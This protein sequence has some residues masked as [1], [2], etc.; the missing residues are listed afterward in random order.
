MSKPVRCPECGKVAEPEPRDVSET[1][2]IRGEEIKVQGKL[3]Y[4]P[5]C[6]SLYL[7]EAYDRLQ[8]AAYRTYRDK[9]R[10]MTPDEIR[11]TREG[12]GFS[13]ELFSRV[14]GIGVASLRRYEGGALQTPAIDTLLH[15]AKAPRTLL[16][17]FERNKESLSAAEAEDIRRKLER[18]VKNSFDKGT[19]LEELLLRSADGEPSEFNGF[20]RLSLD[21]VKGLVAYLLQLSGSSI[22]ITKMCKLLFYCDF[23]FF[24]ESTQSITGL[25]YA[26][27]NYGPVPEGI[28]DMYS[29]FN[30]L[31]ETGVI[32]ITE[33]E[34]PG[35]EGTKRDFSLVDPAAVS[36]LDGEEKELVERVFQKL[37]CFN[38]AKLSKLAHGEKG[39][40]STD[41][42]EKISYLFA[43]KLKA[44]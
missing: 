39:Y 32:E 30:Y 31:R 12:Y 13:Q 40:R 1:W 34:C 18:L 29:L 44:V 4:C 41:P 23:A 5:A 19:H 3:N 35:C 20:R 2:N 27:Y 28:N 26:N 8:E 16:S 24:R 38:A 22:G 43:E 9:H 42:N 25:S 14:L 6:G 15:S 17:L 10:L 36:F 7:D 37:G 21:K 33:E 11:S